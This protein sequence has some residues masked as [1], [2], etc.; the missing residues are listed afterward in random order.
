M[1]IRA[2]HLGEEH[3][4]WQLFFQTIHNVNT[5]HYSQKQLDA[6]APAAFNQILWREKLAKL[7]SFVCV[8]EKKIVG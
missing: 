8:K 5:Q 4:I 7:S 2:Y 3:E 1:K 6:W